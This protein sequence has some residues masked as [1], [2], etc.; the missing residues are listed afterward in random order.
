MLEK[1]QTAGAPKKLH[2]TFRT[3]AFQNKIGGRVLDTVVDT[4]SPLT[5]AKLLNNS[6]LI[7][8]PLRRSI[9]VLVPQV[10]QSLGL[11]IMI[12]KKAACLF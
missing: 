9:H 8:L 4:Q 6:L 3:V 5:E 7:R 11:L 10:V 12:L 2:S 1:T